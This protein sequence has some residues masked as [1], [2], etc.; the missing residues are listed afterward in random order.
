MSVALIGIGDAG[1]N[2][3]EHIH[4]GFTHATAIVINRNHKRLDRS[5]IALRILVDVRKNEPSLITNAISSQEMMLSAMLEEFDHIFLIAGMGGV[6]GTF[7]TPEIA[8]IAQ[9]SGV[10]TSVIAIMPFGFEPASRMEI[11]RQGI[12]MVKKHADRLLILDNQ[13]LIHMPNRER[14]SMLEAFRLF[15]Q[16]VLQFIQR[17]PSE[18]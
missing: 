5:P 9:E 11:A 18:K 10:T 12:A 16:Q 13:E 6:T 14:I 15:D 7:A 1:M 17:A 2:C 8:R 3:L 4:S